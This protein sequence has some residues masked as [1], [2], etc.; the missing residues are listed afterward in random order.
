MP[1]KLLSLV[2]LTVALAACDNRINCSP[3]GPPGQIEVSALRAGSTSVW[4]C[5]DDACSG[6]VALKSDRSTVWIG[7]EIY[8]AKSVRLQVYRG[9]RLTDTFGGSVSLRR[10]SGKGCGCGESIRLAP[11]G[12][13]LQ[14]VDGTR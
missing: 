12:G 1:R 8:D 2:A 11:A 9:E 14:R 6:P 13:V 5:L 7:R 4:V 3:C 10:P